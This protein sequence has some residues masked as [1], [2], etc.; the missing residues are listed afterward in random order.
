VNQA[1]DSAVHRAEKQ[2]ELMRLVADGL[3]GNDLDVRPPEYK[4]TCRLIIGCEGARCALSVG[5]YGDVEWEC[6]PNTGHKANPKKIA[7]LA[8]ALLTGGT[9]EYPCLE[10]GYG[11]PGITFKGIVALELKARGLDVD[12]EVYKDEAYFDAHTEIVVTSPG[13]GEDAKVYVT[14]DGS[15]TWSRDYWAEAATVTWEPEYSGWIADPAKVA[16][17]VVGTITQVMSRLAD[18]KLGKSQ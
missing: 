15:V 3:V 9:G 10:A 1:S 16:D 7:D 13:T 6:R 17:A 8:T 2:G 4:D 12:L 18:G 5:D 14:D 11:H